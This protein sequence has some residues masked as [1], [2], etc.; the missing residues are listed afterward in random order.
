MT[1]SKGYHIVPPDENRCV[2]MTAGV[3]PYQLCD[4]EFR[5]EECP[6][7]LAIRRQV[8]SPAAVGD[9][10]KMHLSAAQ[11]TALKEGYQYSRNHCWIL[12][13]SPHSVRV[14]IEPGFATVIGRPKSIVLPLHGQFAHSGQTCAWIVTAGGTLTLG[15]PVGGSVESSNV[16][17]RES[18]HLLHQYP[19]SEGWLYEVATDERGL[20]EAG[21]VSPDRI[22]DTYA[23]DESRFL[24]ALDGMLRGNQPDGGLTLAD[25]DRRLDSILDLVG[26]A[27]YFDAVR[28]IYT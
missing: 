28:R 5:C 26:P 12:N 7:D 16:L 17:L 6:L 14:G 9:A 23:A 2:W 19:F 21:L 20:E 25:I 22:A 10:S 18:P 4:R 8:R 24:H 1:V 11:Q 27:K 3:L 15:A 13:I